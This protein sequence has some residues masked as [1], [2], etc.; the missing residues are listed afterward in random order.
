MNLLFIYIFFAFF[1]GFF[2]LALSNI[3]ITFEDTHKLWVEFC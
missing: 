2:Q 3:L 1:I